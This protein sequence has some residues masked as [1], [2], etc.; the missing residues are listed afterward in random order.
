M[1]IKNI[2]W[3]EVSIDYKGWKITIGNNALVS[4]PED[5]ANELLR[6]YENMFSEVNDISNVVSDLD[7]YQKKLTA[8]ANISISDEDEIAATDT[9]YTPWDWI[10]IDEENEISCTLEADDFD[11]KDLADETNILAWKQPVATSWEWAP[12]STPTA[13]GLFYLDTTNS[14]MYMSFGTTASTDWKEIA[15]VS[16]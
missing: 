8:W 11:I 6:M 10:A 3:A 5:K 13:I 4:L 7:D 1:I 15:I 12:E 14:K 9:T 16:E 2:S